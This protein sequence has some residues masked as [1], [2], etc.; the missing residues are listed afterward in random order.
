MQI[1]V[2]KIQNQ[3][4]YFYLLFDAVLIFLIKHYFGEAYCKI[5]STSIENTS[6]GHKLSRWSRGQPIDKIQ[7]DIIQ[8]LY[9]AGPIFQAKMAL[10]EKLLRD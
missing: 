8:H 1:F 10:T 5:I 3:T 4:Y 2:N 6:W 9:F 7:K